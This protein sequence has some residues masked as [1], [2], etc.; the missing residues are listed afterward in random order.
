MLQTI[1]QYKDET[2]TVED[3]FSGMEEGYRRGFTQGYSRAMFDAAFAGSNMEAKWWN[4]LGK[5]YTEALLPWRKN[6]VDFDMTPPPM[7]YDTEKGS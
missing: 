3:V 7:Y 2:K 6:R 4:K 5:F 1:K